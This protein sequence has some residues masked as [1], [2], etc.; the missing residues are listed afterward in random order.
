M[1]FNIKIFFVFFFLLN[2]LCFADNI[3]ITEFMAKNDSTLTNETGNTYDWIELYNPGTVDVNLG[4][5]FLTDDAAVLSKW[6]FPGTNIPAKSYLL[7]FASDQNKSFPGEEL[8]T[9]F[10]LSSSGEFL[11]IVKSDSNAVSHSYYPAFP[12]QI[13]D[14]SCGLPAASTYETLLIT[15]SAPCKAFVPIDSSLGSSWTGK[16]FVD[17][18]WASGTTGVGYDNNPTYLPLIG[19]NVKTEMYGVNASCYVRVPFVLDN[20]SE[21][22]SMILKMKYDDG[23]VAYI[24]GEEAE[25]ANAPPG[26]LDWNAAA[27]GLHDDTLATNFV[28]YY[29]PLAPFIGGINEGET[30]VLAIHGLN[31]PSTSSDALFL[32]E[33][34]A[35]FSSGYIT[36]QIAYFFT[37]TPAAPNN[38]GISNLPPII[39][40]AGHSPLVPED[41]ETIT[42]TARITETT[43]PVANVSLHYRV[44]YGSESIVSMTD[45]GGGIYSGN[46]SSTVSFPGDMVRYYI[47]ASDTSGSTFRWPLFAT[48]TDTEYL[49]TIINNPLINTNV[50][51]YHWFVL[52]TGAADTRAGTRCSFFYNDEFYDNIFCRLRGGSSSYQT[53]KPYKFEFNADHEFKFSEKYK[54]ADEINILAAYNDTSYMRDFL[55]WE[56]LKDSSLPYCFAEIIQLRQNSVFFGLEVCVEQVDGHF[57]R[58][59]NINDNGSLYKSP[60]PGTLIELSTMGS[61]EKKRPDDGDFSDMTNFINGLHLPT[62]AQIKTYMLDNVNIPE[63][64]NYLAAHRIF[65]EFDFTA[66]N[67]YLYNDIEDRGEWTI[68]A[69]DKDLTFG[70]IWGGTYVFGNNDYAYSSSGR[71]VASMYWS[72]ANYLYR[73]IIGTFRDMYA[74]RIRTLMDELLQPPDTPRVNLKFENRVYELHGKIK[75]LADMDRAKWGWPVQSDFYNRTDHLDI[76]GG[77][78]ELTN[79]FFA[80]RRTHMYVTHN[81]DNGGMI[82]HAQPESANLIF[83]NIEVLPVSGIKNEQYF[84]LINTNNFAV[85]ISNWQIS[86]AVTFTFFGG[87]VVPAGENVY[88]SPSV[89]FFRYRTISPKA[90]ENNFVVGNFSGQLDVNGE[91][92]FLLN[93]EGNIIASANT[94]PEP[95]LFWILNFGF[96]I[97]YITKRVPRTMK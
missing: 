12:Q 54:R 60:H 31:Y 18:L 79:D 36:N 24:N 93:Y 35:I 96:W 49:G 28:V 17:S 68:Y 69:W 61:L 2:S 26:T 63:V 32:P 27:T 29:I 59:Q 20:V 64:V 41:N 5:W 56:I 73:R 70:M 75:A 72:E 43:L 30:N 10:K 4:G 91:T 77:C 52:N 80:Q 19:L 78:N 14:V 62:E 34:S 11:A 16:S 81:V 40:I 82:P 38:A 88:I 74:R 66:K 50:P 57:L 89:K 85:D 37:P 44:M 1:N 84:E 7:V 39:S 13:A 3:L 22:S 83:G 8:H 23:F 90:G 53:K 97:L 95:M 33:L 9:N 87:T 94:I 46:I 76:D 15:S 21:L 42:V 48:S 71:G 51:V 45:I 67:Y 47:T 25:S 58:R 65:M 86:N 55:S 6:M 92:I